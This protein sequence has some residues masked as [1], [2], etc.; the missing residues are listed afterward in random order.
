MLTSKPAAAMQQEPVEDRQLHITKTLKAPVALVWEAWTK[1]E[2]LVHWWA[3]EGFTTTIRQMEMAVDKEWLLTLHGPDGKHYPNKS[4]FREIIPFRKIV[5]EHVN[6]DFLA[7]VV[8]EP[9]GNDT[10]LEWT[11]LFDTIAL[12]DIVVKT[13]KADEGLKQNVVKLENYLSQKQAQPD[14]S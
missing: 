8:L 5:Y 2:E 14:V 10:L 6:P 11:M 1:P 3:P 9:S 7:T 13:F 4:I 12:F